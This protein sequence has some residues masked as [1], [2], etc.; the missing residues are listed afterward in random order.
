MTGNLTT[1]NRVKAKAV[2]FS[3]CRTKAGA[4]TLYPPQYHFAPAVGRHKGEK[5]AVARIVCE[6]SQPQRPAI[7]NE[8]ENEAERAKETDTKWLFILRHSEETDQVEE[9]GWRR[10][11]A[12]GEGDILKARRSTTKRLAKRRKFRAIRLPSGIRKA[13]NSGFIIYGSI[14]DYIFRR[15]GNSCH[16]YAVRSTKRR[17]ET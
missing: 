2:F 13:I 11:R 9:S 8:G 7:R 1:A 5:V 14:G 17:I 15:H 10:E 3:D 6:E 16:L 4:N 12:G